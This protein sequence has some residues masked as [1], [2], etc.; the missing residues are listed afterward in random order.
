MGHGKNKG[1]EYKMNKK[2]KDVNRRNKIAPIIWN[3]F[4]EARKCP[5]KQ[6]RVKFD[7]VSRSLKRFFMEEMDEKEIITNESK[8]SV[9]FEK[10]ANVYPNIKEIHFLNEYKFTD[11]VLNN[12]MDCIRRKK[13]T[14]EKIKFLYWNYTDKEKPS[15]E[16]VFYDPH[17][18]N[19]NLLK[20]LRKLNW[21][22]KYGK[23]GQTGYKIEVR[24][25]S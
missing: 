12:L 6:Q 1:I 7:V 18:L 25:K 8:W 22:L 23:S 24:R 15:D 2:L 13:N 9:S 5:N 3:K 19:R 11:K 4:D 16:D 14:I 21:E 17:K 20:R 10:I